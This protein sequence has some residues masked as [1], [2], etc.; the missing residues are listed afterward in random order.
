MQDYHIP[1]YP[2][3]LYH[4][5]NR[6]NGDEKIFKEE[7]NYFYFLT[8]YRQHI[9]PVAN[10]LAW[11][12]LPNHY[13][14]L[15]RIK[16]AET[17]SERFEVKKK[18]KPEDDTLLPGF[19]VQQFSNWQNGY[20]KAVNK[21]YRRRG[22]LFMDYIRRVEID[23]DMQFGNTVFYIHK[24]PV[25]HGFGINIGGWPWS[26]YKEYVTKQFG[27]V[28]SKEVIEWFGTMENFLQFHQQPILR[29]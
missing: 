11:C 4:I 20:A 24:N 12:L 14:F 16:P 10:T 8:K 9:G 21:M 17:I 23:K 22:S 7:Q 28:D 25:H 1:L 6:A 5:L 2:G 27:L 3:G 15:V 18:K 26:S 19:I 13:H 29:T